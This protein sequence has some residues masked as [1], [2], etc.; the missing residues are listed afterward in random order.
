MPIV[1]MQNIL[2]SAGENRYGVGAF[3]AVNDLT[4]EAVLAAAEESA[5]PVIVQISV[6]TVAAMGPRLIKAMFGE[7]ASGISVPAALH[8]DH[9]SDTR[10]IEECLE[11][12]WNSV[13]FDGSGLSY[14][15]NLRRTKEVVAMARKHGAAV[16]GE[17]EAVRGVEDE[18][19]SEDEGMIVPLDKA[20]A[21]IR[22]TGIDSFAPAIGTAH[23]MYKGE[24]NVNLDRVAE[25][26][27][28]ASIPIVVHGGTGLSDAVFRELIARGASKINISTQLKIVYA[29]A[30]RGYLNEHPDEYNPL[31]LLAATRE[32]VKEMATAF[33]RVFGS[34]GRA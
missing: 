8:L 17:L 1:S 28:E 3:N 15:E 4:M 19:G 31:K 21:F 6:K 33:M 5:S 30:L 34:E 13:L 32:R 12:G 2:K 29:D 7:M 26:V 9:C 10:V 20:V 23:G 22:D 27:A 25:I 14:E 11:A 24:P 18:V 16:E